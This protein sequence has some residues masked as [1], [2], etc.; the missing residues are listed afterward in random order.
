MISMDTYSKALIEVAT[1]QERERI[2]DN[3]RDRAAD[4]V[5]DG[6]MASAELTLLSKLID[7]LEGE[8]SQTG[9]EFN[10][11]ETPFEGENK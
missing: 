5:A 9:K 6:D 7:W 8:N 11:F 1:L 3:L 2:T 10:Y 4:L